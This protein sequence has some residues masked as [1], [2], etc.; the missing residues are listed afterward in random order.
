MKTFFATF[1]LL[2]SLNISAETFN[3][4]SHERAERS[5]KNGTGYYWDVLRAVYKIEGAE[6]THR[7]VPFVR[8]LAIV[9]NKLVDVAVAAFRTPQRIKKFT[10]PQSRLHFSNYGIII[11][12][13]QNI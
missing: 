1:I 8:C 5:Q 12:F 3:F 9:E 10:Y 4:C 13:N 11:Y 6:I 2:F 7:A